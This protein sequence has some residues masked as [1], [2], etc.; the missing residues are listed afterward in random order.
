MRRKNLLILLMLC[1]FAL[2]GCGGGGGGKKNANK[3]DRIK[4]K[5]TTQMVSDDNS[6]EGEITTIRTME[7]NNLDPSQLN[8]SNPPQIDEQMIRDAFGDRLNVD[9]P[10][11]VTGSAQATCKSK[12]MRNGEVI[13]EQEIAYDLPFEFDA[14]PAEDGGINITSI[15][16]ET[17]SDDNNSTNT[18]TDNSGDPTGD[19]SVIAENVNPADSN[20]VLPGGSTTTA[21]VNSN[22]EP[23]ETAAEEIPDFPEDGSDT[24]TGIPDSTNDGEENPLEIPSPTGEQDDFLTV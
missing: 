20:E 10:I 24:I 18:N 15:N 14:Q 16:T 4:E 6:L 8:C 3:D 1:A 5:T 21:P 2:V 13:D 12:F 9:N 7:G 22:P 11:T 19:P 17:G 23:A